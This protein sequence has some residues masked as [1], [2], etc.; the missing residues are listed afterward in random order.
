MNRSVSSA[1]ANREF[2]RLL[3][4]VKKGQSYVITSHGKPVARI[5][6]FEENSRLA[7]RAHDLLLDRLESQAVKHVGKWTREELY[8]R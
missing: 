1:Q 2:S 5:S 6:P 4:A 7:E 8:E 3:Q